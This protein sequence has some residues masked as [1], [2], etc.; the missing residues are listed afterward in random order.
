MIPA[1]LAV[2]WKSR[3]NEGRERNI[4]GVRWDMSIPLKLF[5]DLDGRNPKITNFQI[6][7][8]VSNVLHFNLMLSTI[9]TVPLVLKICK[10]KAAWSGLS[11]RK[12]VNLIR[13][14]SKPMA[15]ENLALKPNEIVFI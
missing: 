6:L 8:Q 2:R 11:P 10:K 14:R 1:F 13:L 9:R 15:L 3:E 5:L 12:L 4:T 7:R